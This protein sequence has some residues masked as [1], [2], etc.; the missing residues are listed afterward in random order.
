M[1]D[2]R[3]WAAGL[4]GGAGKISRAIQPRHTKKVA[5]LEGGRSLRFKACAIWSAIHL[6]R[7]FVRS[8]LP[9]FKFLA[10]IPP[11]I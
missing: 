4:Q 6:T 5:A 7:L 1:K 3:P 11:A 9:V 2:R 8:F 10:V